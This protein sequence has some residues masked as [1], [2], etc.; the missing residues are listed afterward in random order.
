MGDTNSSRITNLDVKTLDYLSERYSIRGMLDIGCGSGGMVDAAIGRGI[1]AIGIDLD[2][3][4]VEAHPFVMAHDFT[5]RPLFWTAVDL[6]W[7]GQFINQIE[8][9]YINNYLETFRLARFLFLFDAMSG[10]ARSYSVNA[11]E[12]GYWDAHLQSFGFRLE[13]TDTDWIRKF[14]GNVYTR[15]TGQFFLNTRVSEISM[16]RRI[17]SLNLQL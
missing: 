15:A 12:S 17:A 6:I 5:L 8:E 11:K 3:T 13:E 1:D 2:A 10:E 9:Q 7:C 16:D 4:I 14:A